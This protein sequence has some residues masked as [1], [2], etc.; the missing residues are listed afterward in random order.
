M[1]DGIFPEHSPVLVQD[2]EP[3][4]LPLARSQPTNQRTMNNIILQAKSL[5]SIPLLLVLCLDISVQKDQMNFC[6]K[7]GNQITKSK[8]VNKIN[9]LYYNLS[10]AKECASSS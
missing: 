7:V 6:F 1:F 4:T 9:F 10:P 3:D 8:P 5:A 2:H